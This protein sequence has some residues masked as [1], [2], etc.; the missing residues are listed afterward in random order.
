LNGT[1][2][3]LRK[4]RISSQPQKKRAG[5]ARLSADL[6]AGVAGASRAQRGWLGSTNGS[7]QL[8]R[9]WTERVVIQIESYA[10]LAGGSASL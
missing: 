3:L 8:K 4:Q 1:N 10:R 6:S 7:P 2:H 5:V 9:K